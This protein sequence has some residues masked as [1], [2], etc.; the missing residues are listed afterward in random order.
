MDC[1]SWLAQVEQTSRLW[2]LLHR[3]IMSWFKWTYQGALRLGLQVKL[4]LLIGS[5]NTQL[6]DWSTIKNHDLFQIC[7]CRIWWAFN[8]SNESSLARSK[9]KGKGLR[10]ILFC[11][12]LEETITIFLGVVRRGTFNL[13]TLTLCL[14]GTLH[15]SLIH[16]WV[17]GLWQTSDVTVIHCFA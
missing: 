14:V 15:C 10:T 11:W 16:F 7:F 13:S 5:L 8:D 4:L 12:S 6:L 9:I 3:L 17:F 2:Q 1:W